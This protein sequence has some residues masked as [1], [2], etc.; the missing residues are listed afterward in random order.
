M[1][2]ERKTCITTGGKQNKAEKTDKNSTNLKVF[3]I[4]SRDD[5]GLLQ[6][7][8]GSRSREHED[9]GHLWTL[10]Q[11]PHNRVFAAARSDHEHILHF[12]EINTDSEQVWTI[13]TDLF[14]AIYNDSITSNDSIVLC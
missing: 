5:F 7:R 13:T 4:Q 14:F 2:R 1:G 12:Y 6:L 10:L 3:E 8:D 9:T 11:F